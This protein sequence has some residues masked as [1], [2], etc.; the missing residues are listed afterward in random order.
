MARLPAGAGIP[1]TGPAPLPLRGLRQVAASKGA[2]TSVADGAAFPGVAW[3]MQLAFLDLPIVLAPM[4]GG[5]SAQLVAAVSNARGFGI[6]PCAYL[7]PEQIEAQIAA[8]RAATGRPFGVNLFVEHPP[9][10]ADE[11]QLRH[12]HD[13]LRAYRAELGIPHPPSPAQ[14]PDRY[15]AQLDA[16]LAARPAVFTFTFGIPD[17]AVLGRF[18]GA[19]IFTIGTATTVDEAIAL[20][21]AGADGVF[22]QGYEAGAHR[23]TFLAPVEESLVGTLALVPQ[24]VDAVRIPVFAAGGIGDGRGVAAVLA[25]GA[26]AAAI[27]TSFLLATESTAS[28]AYR[29]ALLA[30]SSRR[31]VLTRAFSGRAARGIRNRFID[32]IAEPDD[33]APYPFQNA[34]TR[35]V[36]N[37]AAD[38]GRA[39]FLSLWA[40]Q[41]ARLA[42]AKPAAEIVADLMREATAAARVSS[43][44]LAGSGAAG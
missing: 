18:R 44:R 33:L 15:A 39:E 1:E 41:A 30:E 32:E 38:Q 35:D 43:A 22:A 13:R 34:I 16:I 6:L 4:S 36:R 42:R 23:G 25:L 40:G 5:A 24:V 31:T 28:R 2:A 10:A 20:E 12:A 27:G 29:E 14:P 26:Q 11:A 17:A 7:T 21:N 8:V 37:A 9:Y 19:G 3:G